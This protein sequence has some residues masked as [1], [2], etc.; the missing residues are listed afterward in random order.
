MLKH[1][2]I[3]IDE[4]VYRKLQSLS[5]PFRTHN[6]DRPDTPNKTLRMILRLPPFDKKNN[7]YVRQM[8]K[9]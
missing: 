5:E 1:D 8:R 3:R 4:E 9:K 2:L 6:L 7:K